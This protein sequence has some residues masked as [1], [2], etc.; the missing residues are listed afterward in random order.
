MDI[1]AIHRWATA[2]GLGEPSGVD[3]PH[4]LPGLIP[5]RAWKRS[6]LNQPWYPGETLSV[7]IGQGAVSVTPISLA[8]MMSTVASGGLRPTPHMLQA[9]RGTS[10]WDV[11][12]QPGPAPVALRPE[13]VA[14]VRDGLWMAVNRAGTAR[15]ARIEGRDVIGKTG[16]A[17][18][19]SLE[20]LAAVE[21]AGEDGR[22]FRDHGWFVFAAPR[23][24]PR[25]AG[26]VFAEHS[27]HGYLAGA[28][29]EA[30]DGDVTSPST[31]NRSVDV[32]IDRRLHPHIDWWLLAAVMLASVMGLVM[33]YSATYEPTT[34]SAGPQVFRQLLALGIGLLAMLCCMSVDYRLRPAGVAV[35]YVR[36]ARD[37]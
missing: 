1:D 16:T 18:V 14:A 2:L 35:V 21:A 9:V 30:D 20:G 27:E 11:A 29:C 32:V 17:Q 15:R 7:A 6:A 34:G 5:S 22:R 31:L 26:V 12:A 23:N 19:I 13:T 28:D 25:I 8:V 4:E 24:D 36:P 33:I 10:G 37:C 3:L